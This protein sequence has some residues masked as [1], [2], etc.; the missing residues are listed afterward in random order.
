MAKTKKEFI[1]LLAKRM[2]TGEATAKQ[3]IDPQFIQI[4]REWAKIKNAPQVCCQS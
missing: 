1:S 4:M 3:R 2:N